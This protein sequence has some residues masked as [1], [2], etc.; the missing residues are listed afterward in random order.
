MKLAEGFG[1][2]VDLLGETGERGGDGGGVHPTWWR[3]A[4][5]LVPIIAAAAFVGSLLAISR[6]SAYDEIR[7]LD[8]AAGTYAVTYLRCRVEGGDCS[9]DAAPPSLAVEGRQVLFLTLYH[10]GVRG[11]RRNVEADGMLAA[12][13]EL[14]DELEA[15]AAQRPEMFEG[16]NLRLDVLVARGPV[17]ESVPALFSLSVVPGLDGL[18]LETAGGSAWLLPHELVV[19]GALTSFKPFPFMDLQFGVDPWAMRRVLESDLDVAPGG[20]RLFRFRAQSFLEVGEGEV[21]SLY[22]NAPPEPPVDRARIERAVRAAADWVLSAEMEGGQFHYK[23]E[24]YLDEYVD[25]DYSLG[26]HAGTSLFLLQVFEHTQDPRYLASAERALDFLWARVRRPCGVEDAACVMAGDQARLG[27]SAL[28]A[29]AFAEHALLRDDARSRRRAVQLGRFLRFMQKPNGDFYHRFEPGTG[30]DREAYHFYYSGEAAYAL[31][32]L[33]RADRDESAWRE[34]VRRTLEFWVGDYWDFFAG[35]FFFVEEHWTCLAIEAA[36]PLFDDDRYADFCADIAHFLARLL[37]TEDSSPYPDFRGG[38]GFGVF[39]PPHTTPT[40]SRTEAMV[41][42]YRLSVARGESDAEL[43]EAI[44]AAYRFLLAAQFDERDAPL[45][46]DPER[47]RG[48]FRESLVVPLVRID[49]NQHAGSALLRGVDL[50]Y[51]R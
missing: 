1:V 21:I 22:R 34:A 30:I 44:R 32:R 41:A 20:G 39:F 42:A 38:A 26:R 16:V 28:A 12:L 18:G 4:V 27:H 33:A 13:V 2:G 49:Y 5:W 8:T 43:A 6:W 9:L 7:E 40:A 35:G 37:H 14:G 23:Y 36:D 51:P 25:G 29:A 50:L 31:A 3:H 45:L 17:L 15:S 24:P 46:P 48:G 11:F 19:S 10:D 47:A